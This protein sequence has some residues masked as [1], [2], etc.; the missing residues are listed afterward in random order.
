[1]AAHTNERYRVNWTTP[2][3]ASAAA[4]LAS[5]ADDGPLD[6]PVAGWMGTAFTFLTAGSAGGA[7]C[8]TLKLI[9]FVTL[10]GYIISAALRA[11]SV[12]FVIPPHRTA[13]LLQSIDACGVLGCRTRRAKAV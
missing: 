13:R 4:R 3:N 5:L 1:M 8:V 9:D 7:R 10:Q 11:E 2:N 12:T 6:V